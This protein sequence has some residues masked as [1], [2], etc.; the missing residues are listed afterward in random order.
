MTKFT[1]VTIRRG[2]IEYAGQEEANGEGK[3]ELAPAL[4]TW[5]RGSHRS[6]WVVKVT[7]MDGNRLRY[8]QFGG[9]AA[10][11]PV[12]AIGEAI[13]AVLAGDFSGWLGG[14]WVALR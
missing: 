11:R 10:G 5:T 13:D 8:A 2:G 9:N 3:L 1:E 4:I 6:E 7:V 12:R 14:G